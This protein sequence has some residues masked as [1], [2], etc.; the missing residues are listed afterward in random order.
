MKSRL[1]AVVLAAAA[2]TSGIAAPVLA[3]PAAARAAAGVTYWCIQVHSPWGSYTESGTPLPRAC[4]HG[5]VLSGLTAGVR[6]LITVT[7]SSSTTT[8]ARLTAF[9]RSGR[10]WARVAGPWTARIG[11]DGM[12]RPGAKIEGDDLTRKAPTG[13]GSSSAC[14]PNPGVASPLA[15]MP[16]SYHVRAA[17]TTRCSP[18]YNEWVDARHAT[19]AGREPEPHAQVPAYDYAAVIAYNTAA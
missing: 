17:T 12:A 16:I 5:Y 18:R 8:Y 4:K 7:A 10:G 15:G 11:A 13:S 14:S 6:K 9:A 3:G 2:M 19:A 1:A